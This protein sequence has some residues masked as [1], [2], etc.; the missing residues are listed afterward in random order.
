MSV[1][2]P[3]D[4]IYSAW[5]KR[6]YLKTYD[7]IPKAMEYAADS[8]LE[9]KKLAQAKDSEMLPDKAQLPKKKGGAR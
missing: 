9:S 4:E 7:D 8:I 2:N 3:L 1:D 6:K 5:L